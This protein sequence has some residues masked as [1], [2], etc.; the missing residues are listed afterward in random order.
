MAQDAIVAEFD[1]TLSAAERDLIA[2]A[3][4]FGRR[5][6]APRAPRFAADQAMPL[7][8]LRTACDAG[9]ARIE[10]PIAASGH[11]FHFAAKMRVVEELAKSDFGFAFSLV[12]HHNATLRVSAADPAVASRLLPAMLRG[13]LVGCAAY[14]EPGHGSDLSHL[15]TTAEKVAAGWR[16]NGSKTWVTNGAVAEVA[17][18]LAQTEPG[19][20]GR[21]LATF[22]VEAARPGFTR[23]APLELDGV[24]AIGLGGFSLRD[25]FL[26]DASLL[27]APG[28]SF[29]SALK[30]INGA[31]TYVAAMCAG[32]LESAIEAALDYGRQ[33]KA[34]GQDLVDFQGLR[35]SLVD[36]QT[37]LA[38]LRLLTYRA[39]TAIESGRAVEQDAA[40]AKKFAAERTLPHIAACVQAMGAAG[41]RSELPLMRH[42]AACKA[43]AF[44]DGSTEMMNER[45]GKRMV[46][47]CG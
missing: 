30:G 1:A 37:D 19:S 33:R 7:D 10:L 15:E 8:L 17:I 31:R 11:G 4:D 29:N 12:N 47:R 43:A 21:G 22:V 41:L 3:R 20:G 42:L 28:D 5:E 44:A 34:F 6:V 35:W 13:E 36:A 27:D 25:Y 2:A 45:L 9:L 26:E 14:T 46:E 32:M 18:A 39:A 40:R 24:H 38:A 23:A 16:L